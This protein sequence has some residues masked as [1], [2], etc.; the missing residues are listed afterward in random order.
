MGGSS[1]P[2]SWASCSRVNIWKPHFTTYSGVTKLSCAPLSNKQV[3][4]SSSMRASP[5]FLGPMRCGKGSGFK[6]GTLRAFLTEL[7]PSG[8][9]PAECRGFCLYFGF[10]CCCCFGRPPG[11]QGPSYIFCLGAISDK[12]VRTDRQSNASVVVHQP[13]WPWPSLS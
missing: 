13:G 5:Q 11:L 6:Q 9:K 12:V 3:V 10:R 2:I 7:P 8:E 4:S 1:P